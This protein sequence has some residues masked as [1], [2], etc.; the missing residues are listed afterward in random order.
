MTDYDN[1]TRL[2]L[3][4][5][6][7]LLESP[8]AVYPECPQS[9]YLQ[10]EVAA[11]LQQML[12]N[13]DEAFWIRDLAS[14]RYLYCSSAVETL[15]CVPIADM[16]REP[17]CILS[18][19]HPDDREF[20]AVAY[21]EEYVHENNQDIEYRIQTSPDNLHWV[22]VRSFPIRNAT[23]DIY[24][25]A[26]VASNVT[27]RK[28]FEN[29]YKTIIQASMDGFWKLSLEGRILDCN[30]AA[31]IML[32]Y[33]RQELLALSIKD[34]DLHED[35]AKTFEH[36]RL[37]TTQGMDRFETRHRCKDGRVLDIEV[38]TYITPSPFG[39]H[40]L[41]FMR[42]ITTR[43]LAEVALV[44]QESLL[45]TV[46]DFSEDSIFLL[47]REFRVRFMNPA[48]VKLAQLIGLR[49]ELDGVLGKNAYELFGDTPNTHQLMQIDEQVMSSGKS[50]HIEERVD[51]FVGTRFLLAF[52]SPCYDAAGNL[53]GLVGISRDITEHKFAEIERLANLEKQRDA[54]VRDVHHRIKNNLQ[55]VIGLMRQHISARPETKAAVEA[56]IGQV[57]TI[58]VVHGLHSRVT[59]SPL[60]LID[61][62][63]AIY[64]T[65]ASLAM[66]SDLKQIEKPRA[67]DIYLE[68]GAAVVVALILNELIQNA[69][70]HSH[71][72]NETRIK[73]TGNVDQCAIHISNPSSPLPPGFNLVVGS[74]CGT[75]LDLVRMLLPRKGA[76]LDIHHADGWVVAKF[77]LY[78]PVIKASQAHQIETQMRN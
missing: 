28:A 57:H 61:M 23:G 7:R 12:C 1:M 17:A 24:R 38:S 66:S 68:D 46:T 45:R 69:L 31:C 58:A 39:G 14:H 65:A 52:R 71:L 62:L 56:A 8:I 21:S 53:V 32:G 63:E 67:N 20:V 26:Y 25:V 55:G 72:V 44:E 43:K 22:H 76:A 13:V 49:P 78:P 47:D 75:G 5:R 9:D 48:G 60:T 40:L 19:V 50:S 74:G 2:Q 42:D 16:F 11:N 29:E 18:T 41:A 34:I 51:T 59:S 15:L 6:L 54:L 36:I 4:E 30:D 3:I 33:S 64:S 73:V 27:E 77:V 10:L 35:Q 70:K 37:V